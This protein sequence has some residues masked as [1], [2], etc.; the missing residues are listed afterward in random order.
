M[1]NAFLL[2]IGDIARTADKRVFLR[3]LF[4]VA[5]AFHFLSVGVPLAQTN[6]STAPVAANTYV[7]QL[8]GQRTEAE[9][10]SAF[11]ELQRKSAELGRRDVVIRRVEHPNGARYQGEIGPFGTAGEADALCDRLMAAGGACVVVLAPQPG[12]AATAAAPPVAPAASE[13]R[14]VKTLIIRRDGSVGNGAQQSTAPVAVPPAAPVVPG[15]PKRIKTIP[16]RP[17][18]SAVV[19]PR[20]E[21]TAGSQP[22]TAAPAGASY[23]VQI[24]AQRTES[25]LLSAFQALQQKYP[26][27]LGG[28]DL[29]IRRVDLADRGVWYRGQI[30]PFGT[31]TQAI[32]F[33]DNLKAAGGPCMVTRN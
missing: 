5:A 16:I 17:D 3:V 8:A 25:D 33:C 19:A 20:S 7:V 32:A 23:A 10:R 12:A 30:G 18:G 24:S 6:S 11:Q 28:R 4:F 14:R 21:S 9:V 15:E 27:I 2:R 1:A 31:P 29:L 26:S 22:A 13:P